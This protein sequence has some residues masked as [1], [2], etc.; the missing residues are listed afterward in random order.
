[1]KI[2]IKSIE[3]T[4]LLVTSILYPK[5]DNIGNEGDNKRSSERKREV[6]TDDYHFESFGLVCQL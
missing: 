2:T 4:Q 3:K 5:K 6:K 1:M